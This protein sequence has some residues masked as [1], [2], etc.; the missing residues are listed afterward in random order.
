MLTTNKA[1]YNIAAGLV[2]AEYQ[3]NK[4]ATLKVGTNVSYVKDT[5]VYSGLDDTA[6]NTASS[7]T[8]KE[9]K[10][11]VFAEGEANMGKLS[12]ILAQDMKY[13]KCHIMTI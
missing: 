6:E 5:K 12:A 4:N 9:T 3:L 11:A 1:T 2:E 10:M 13:S 7:L 8:S